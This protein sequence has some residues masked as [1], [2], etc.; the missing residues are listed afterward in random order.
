MVAW[1]SSREEIA[2]TA[3]RTGVTAA[4]L[5]AQLELGCARLPLHPEIWR[6]AQAQ[7]ALGRQTALVTVNVDIF[8]R[9]IAPALQLSQVFDVVVNSADV[10]ELDKIALC[11]IAFRRL[12]GCAF[13]N[14]LLIDDTP[15]NVAAFRARGGM[16]YQFT[17]DAAFAAWQCVHLPTDTA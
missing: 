5:L 7:R 13:H 17:T 15:H 14:S 9:V 8:S 1:G 11:E 4:A 6:F 2:D 16:A 3:A 12:D 10:H